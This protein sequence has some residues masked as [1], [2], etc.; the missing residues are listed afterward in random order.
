MVKD[1]KP[2]DD[3]SEEP[4]TE[5]EQSY[6]EMEEPNAEQSLPE[7][8]LEPE[9]AETPE[10]DTARVDIVTGDK[11]MVMSAPVKE[12]DEFKSSFKANSNFQICR[13]L[14]LLY[15]SIQGFKFS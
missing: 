4:R 1:K 5:T 9:A 6:H 3:M 10:E 11:R 7:L 13:S 15:S 14:T 2:T 12:F 8:E